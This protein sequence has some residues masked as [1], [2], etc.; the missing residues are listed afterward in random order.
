MSSSPDHVRPS[1]GQRSTSHNSDVFR[2]GI[3]SSGV[4]VLLDDTSFLPVAHAEE[5]AE[6]G[7][8]YPGTAAPEPEP[9]TTL[10][11]PQNRQT[12][13]SHVLAVSAST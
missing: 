13:Q 11:G 2:D 10:S 4:H 7:G 9:A 6:L 8:E 5:A 12:N 3:A 1:A